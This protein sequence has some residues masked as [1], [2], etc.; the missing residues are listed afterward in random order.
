MMDKKTWLNW[1]IQ[2]IWGG[3]RRFWSWFTWHGVQCGWA[4]MGHGVFY[5]IWHFGPFRIQFGSAQSKVISCEEYDAICRQKEENFK[6]QYDGLRGAYQEREARLIK[7]HK[8]CHANFTILLKKQQEAAVFT[9]ARIEAYAKE[10]RAKDRTVEADRVIEMMDGLL[11]ALEG[12]V[13]EFYYE[14]RG[15]ELAEQILH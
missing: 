8:E 10:L 6:F 3:D 13:G 14:R 11:W 4:G 1:P 9:Y 12:K 2:F 15:N 5:W 7:S